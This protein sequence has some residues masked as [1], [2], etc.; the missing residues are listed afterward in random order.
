[1]NRAPA[2]SSRTK[3]KIRL[4]GAKPKRRDV[5]DLVA[6]RWRAEMKRTLP[7]GRI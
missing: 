1:M 6:I 3:A 2:P 5:R 4:C 7:E